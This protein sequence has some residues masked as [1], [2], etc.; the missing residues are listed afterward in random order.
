MNRA[1]PITAIYPGSFDPLTRGHEDIA[2]RSLRIADR[3]LVAVAY[4]A[5]HVKK[6]LFSVEERLELITEVFRDEPRV[7]AVS[8]QGLLVDFARQRDA[9]VVIRG[10]RAVSDFEYELQMAQMNQKLWDE[11]ETVF[12]VPEGE[13]SFLSSSLVREV[14][15]LNGDVGPFVSPP[16]LA[17]VNRKFSSR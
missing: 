15:S 11:I 12:L 8:F 13:Y 17:A 7:E 3:L 5:T 4:T 14:A 10:L 6:G 1:T 2:R 16:V 9:H